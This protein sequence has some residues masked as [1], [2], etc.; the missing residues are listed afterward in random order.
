MG[1]K[2]GNVLWR[3]FIWY[4]RGRSLV[5]GKWL[6]MLSFTGIYKKR[7]ESYIKNCLVEPKEDEKG[8]I[9]CS[10]EKGEIIAHLDGYAII[11]REKYEKLI[12]EK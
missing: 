4:I 10:N 6:K 12:K 3:L 7:N 1:G 2:V 9:F 11:P 5:R 8:A